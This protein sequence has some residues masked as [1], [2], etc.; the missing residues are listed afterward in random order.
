MIGC[1]NPLRKSGKNPYIIL[2]AFCVGCH[3][4]NP[5]IHE[6]TVFVQYLL[7]QNTTV[8][9]LGNAESRTKYLFPHSTPPGLSSSKKKSTP[10]KILA[11]KIGPVDSFRINDIEVTKNPDPS[12]AQIQHQQTPIPS[13]SKPFCN[14]QSRYK[15]PKLIRS[16]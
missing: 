2:S 10:K 4:S 9:C 16:S 6:C 15:F 13:T 11:I 5:Q 7:V 14:D 12:G 8:P 1:L 3:S